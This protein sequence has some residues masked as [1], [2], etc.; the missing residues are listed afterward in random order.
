MIEGKRSYLALCS[1]LAVF[2]LVGCHEIKEESASRYEFRSKSS[3]DEYYASQL[4]Q[5]IRLKMSE[6]EVRGIL[7]DGEVTHAGG[8][9]TIVSGGSCS[10]SSPCMIAPVCVESG[11]FPYCTN[12]S[13]PGDYDYQRPHNTEA[14]LD[15]A[16]NR[17]RVLFYRIDSSRSDMPFV[18]KNDELI[19]W[20]KS[21]IRKYEEHLPQFS[22]SHVRD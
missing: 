8:G 14:F 9:G 12:Y 6:Q 19:G 7:G 18:F 15:E 16:D 21:E 20:G 4:D 11:W 2:M 22:P 17:M 3:M 10:P 5:N 1:V 13:Y